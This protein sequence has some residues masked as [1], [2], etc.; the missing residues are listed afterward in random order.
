MNKLFNKQ[1]GTAGA[2][3]LGFLVLMTGGS[4][5]YTGSRSVTQSISGTTL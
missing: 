4:F 1:A 2:V 3:G 5:F